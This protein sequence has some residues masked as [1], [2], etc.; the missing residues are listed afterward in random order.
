MNIGNNENLSVPNGIMKDTP[1]NDKYRTISR[2][3]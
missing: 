2:A 1:N 3:K